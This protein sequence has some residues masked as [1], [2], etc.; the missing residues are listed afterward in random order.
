MVINPEYWSNGI[1]RF[2]QKSFFHPFEI[3]SRFVFGVGF[4]FYSHQTLYPILMLIIGYS[5]VAVG[6][7]LSI[8][9]P[10]MHKQFAVW[11]AQRFKRFFRP[12]GVCS[13]AIG[14]FIIYAAL[15]KVSA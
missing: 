14:L 8:T 12:A 10:S 7:G 9:P 11:S 15:W 6:V 2:S 1:V 13:F 3:L 5:L 4:I